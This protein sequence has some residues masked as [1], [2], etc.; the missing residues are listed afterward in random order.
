M[1][2]TPLI[3]TDRRIVATVDASA[4]AASVADHA[5]WAATRL[6]APLEFVHV[7]DRHPETA[8]KID[9]SGT[10][11]AGG[12]EAVLKELAQLDERR[13]HLAQERGALL[14]QQVKRR[15][16]EAG[17]SPVDARMRHGT[18]VDSLTELEAGVRLF[19]LGK[20][21]ESAGAASGHLG[22]NLERVVRAVHRPLLI[23]SRTFRPVQRFSI[24]FDG[25][26]TTKKGI[27]MIAASPLFSG[28]PCHVVMAGAESADARAQL[29]WAH[30]TLTAA[31]FDVHTA[32]RPGEAEEVIG[33][34]VREQN[35]DLLVMG[36]YGHS[37]IRRL[38]V[39]STTTALLQSANC[40]VLLIR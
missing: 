40:P 18:L 29:Q 17:V 34:Y 35:I 9:F 26:S 7:L 28:L 37:R 36:A 11:E 2:T 3:Q 19:V 33:D 39:G 14:L 12:G 21:G 23:A 25:S 4:S 1:T 20:Y 8:P 38:I 5:A 27:E 10:L 32:I 22:A 15:A 24:A 16:T 31:G 30:T 13:S 6:S